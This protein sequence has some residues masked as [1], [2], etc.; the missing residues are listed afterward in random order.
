MLDHRD[1]DVG[2]LGAQRAD[3]VRQHLDRRTLEGADREPF[4]TAGEEI[5]DVA[6]RDHEAIEHD[7]GVAQQCH[8]DRRERDRLGSAGAIEHRRPDHS[9]QRGDLL[10]HG[11]L[12]E[13]KPARRLPERPLARHGLECHQMAHLDVL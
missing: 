5:G 7:V 6:L 13:A 3:C 8:A 4:A 9:L 12:A 11:R 2:A 1:L 10:A